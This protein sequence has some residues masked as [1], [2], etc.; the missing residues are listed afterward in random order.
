MTIQLHHGGCHCG[1]VRFAARID[2]QS[3]VIV[4]NCSICRKNGAM[5]SAV[6][7]E[8]FTLEQGE[9]VLT[10]YHFNTGKIAHQFCGTCGV[11]SFA[12]LFKGGGRAVN[13]RTLDDVDPDSVPTMPF[14][15]ASL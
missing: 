6:A 11:E 12:S 5:L 13:V 14:D 1:A 7:D 9:D 3:P 15:G 2:L 8:D 4:C 10:T